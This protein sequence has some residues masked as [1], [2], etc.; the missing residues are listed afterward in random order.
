[1][2]DAR[3]LGDPASWWQGPHLDL[4]LAPLAQRGQAVLG[5]DD[6]IDLARV[7]LV[8]VAL[9][10]HNAF[11]E[12]VIRV[13]DDLF[14]C[15]DREGRYY[16]PLPKGADLIQAGFDLRFVDC[17]EPHLIE[18]HPPHALLLQFPGDAQRV[19]PFLARR[20][21]WKNPDP[22]PGQQTNK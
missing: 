4:T 9:R 16:D 18:I 15:T 2:S 11:N 12:V 17:A 8:K 1:M 14:A 13:A 21:F 10:W 7:I 5:P 3:L 19:L 20:G 22:L 6:T